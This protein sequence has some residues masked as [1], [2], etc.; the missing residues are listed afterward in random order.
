MI[1]KLKILLQNYKKIL[2]CAKNVVT[3]R[4]II[5]SL[6]VGPLN[7]C[8]YGTGIFTLFAF[9]HPY[10]IDVSRSFWYGNGL[11]PVNV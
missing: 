1:L 2:I 4:Q 3:L 9:V 7:N 6:Y 11:M 8:Y 5:G 10:R